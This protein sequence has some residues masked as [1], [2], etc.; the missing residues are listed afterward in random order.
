VSVLTKYGFTDLLDFLHVDLALGLAKKVGL[1]S[2]DYQ[3]MPR[4]KRLRLAAEELGPT[5]VKFG[6]ILSTRDD[7]LSSQ[8][9]EEL[10]KLQEEVSP[11]SYQEIEREL[12]RAYEIE[13]LE[14]V[15]AHFDTTPLATASISQVHKAQLKSGEWV[16]VKVQRPNIL[17]LM[18]TDLVILS[19][20][21]ALIQEQ[22]GDPDD[23]ANWSRILED[24]MKYVVE[25]L[26]F[27]REARLMLR[28]G[29]MFDDW[30]E[31]HVPKVYLN[32]SNRK[33]LVQ[34]YIDGH[35][36]G[37]L[38]KFRLGVEEK[39]KIGES[40]IRS[41][42]VMVFQEGV[43]HGDP[44]PGNLRVLS[45]NTLV[46]LDFGMVGQLDR[47]NMSLITRVFWGAGRGDFELVAR[48]FHKICRGTI[49]GMNQGLVTEMR[50]LILSYRKLS[51]AY[52]H[53][54]QLLPSIDE[55]LRR[56]K[57]RLP[58]ELSLLFKS[59]ISMECVIRQLNANINLMEY[60][61]PQ[62]QNVVEKQ[63][64]LDSLK[65]R[66][67][68][69]SLLVYDYLSEIPDD[70]FQIL[71]NIQRNQ[72]ESTTRH[73][74]MEYWFYSLEIILNRAVLGLVITGFLIGSSF[75][76]AFNRNQENLLYFL[77]LSGYILAGGFAVILVFSILKVGAARKD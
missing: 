7:I 71:K 53:M 4:A 67:T 19:Y 34:E 15:F 64:E 30:K 17:D 54:D 59:L 40:L 60:L 23:P 51:L 55:M 77:G 14:E 76:L 36:L 18:Q 32:Y 66:F 56:N 25:E 73:K 31:V 13:S 65:S 27:N 58:T 69:R 21:A 75:L 24:F 57:L 33:V 68:D 43:F 38:D 50:D 22:L 49:L 10:Q 2:K 37:N 42:F 20:I 41:F 9:L 44:H 28:F 63:L 72:A 48:S 1:V 11:V 6:Q 45:D 8:Y 39:K 26:D 5:F 16:I 47:E 74:R 35:S 62:V 61:I 29:D 52:I 12:L 3:F 46:F 70:L